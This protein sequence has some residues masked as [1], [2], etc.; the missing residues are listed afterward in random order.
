[1][2]QTRQIFTGIPTVFQENLTQY[3]ADTIVKSIEISWATWGKMRDESLVLG[4]VSYVKAKNGRGFERIFS[5]SIKEEQEAGIQQ[6]IPDIKA[7]LMPDSML[8][9]P[10]TKPTDLAEILLYKGFA[11]DDSAPCMMM[12][13]DDYDEMKTECGDFIIAPVTNMNLPDWLNIIN[14]ALFDGEM[15]TLE[16]ISDVWV[17]ENTYLYLGLI[18]DKPVTTCMTILDGET[19]VLDMVGTLKDYR[20]RGLASTLIDRALT[21]LRRKGVKSVSL[22]AE[23]DGVVYKK[24]GFKECFKRVVATYTGK[25]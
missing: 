18:R 21:D 19:S 15:I 20:R 14:A 11:I 6:M 23:A 5:V 13:L 24:L 8:I 4:D 7:G 9:T 22:R 2:C 12:N 25:E 10:N 1:M 3:E 17:L 16:Q